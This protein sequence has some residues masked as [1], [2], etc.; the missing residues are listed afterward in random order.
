ML[1]PEEELA[2]AEQFGVARAQVRRDHLISHLLAALSMHLADQVIFFGG[3]ALSRSLL[4]NGRLSEDLDLIAVGRRR[5]VAE[6]VERHLVRENRREFP[7]MNWQPTLSSVRDIEPAV[8]TT[9]DGVSVRIQLLGQ[10]GYPPWPVQASPLVQRYS[11]APAA[12]LVVPT[13]AAFAAWKTVAWT[14]RA[15]PRDLFDLWSLAGIGAIDGE[16]AALR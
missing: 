2:V 3:T 11:D 13:H 15:A 6:L 12:T 1:A 5:D 9:V 14:D 10:A 8:L 16:A 4:P 7:G